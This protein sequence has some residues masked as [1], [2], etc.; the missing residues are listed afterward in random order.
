MANTPEE[1]AHWRDVLRA[2]DG[3]MQYHVGSST[4]LLASSHASYHVI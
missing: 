1:R 2:F 4:S 3:Y